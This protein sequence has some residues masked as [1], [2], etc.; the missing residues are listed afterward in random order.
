M[1]TRFENSFVRDENTAK[2]IYRYWFFRKPTMVALYVILAFYTLACIFGLSFDFEDAK[3]F[4]FPFFTALLIPVL[5]IISYRSQ[6]KTMVNRDREMARG[7][8]LVTRI[9]V[10]DN[11]FTVFSLDSRTS[12]LVSD[13]K[14]AFLTGSYIV[15]I[16][17]ARLMVI[18]KKDSFTI[19]DTGSFLAFL[20]EKSIK[21]KGQKK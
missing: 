11:E 7:S 15:V 6:V 14:Y 3:D 12:I 20:R 17:K 19:G 8:E 2:E 5:M 1:E 10:N 21:I 18:L 13:L 4:I 16:T 9:S